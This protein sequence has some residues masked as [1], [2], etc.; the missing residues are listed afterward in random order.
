MKGVVFLL[1]QC[2]RS[3]P[4]MGCCIDTNLNGTTGQESDK[5]LER[6]NWPRHLHCYELIC[7]R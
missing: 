6:G 1:I 3:H 7:K 4:S 5:K 2:S